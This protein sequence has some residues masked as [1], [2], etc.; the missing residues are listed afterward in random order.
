MAFA[1]PAVEQFAHNPV[2][3]YIAATR[4]PFLLA[5]LVPC[6]IGMASAVHDGVTF[7]WLAAILTMVGAVIAQAGVNV[8]NDYYDSI[9]GTDAQNTERL[10]PFTGGSRFIQNGILSED[11]AWKF[12]AGLLVATALIGLVLLPFGGAGLALVG[13]IGIVIGWA[14]SAPPL[15]LNG[16]GLGELSVAIGF[17]TLI[18]VGADMVQR[19]E[20]SS[21]PMIAAVPYAL[22]V[23][24]LLY[25]NQFPD[26]KAD[27]AV[28]KHHWVVRLGPARARWGY[29]V[30]I[31]IAYLTLLASVA[32]G[33]LPAWA[34]LGLVSLPLSLRAAVELLRYAEVPARLVPAIQLTIAAMVT[35]GITLSVGLALS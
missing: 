31:S 19:G 5:S 13:L 15:L 16:R 1:E 35:H 26:R 29:L 22:F 28:G 34:L 10:F 14:Y 24:C 6:F 21:L 2:G 32:S 11:Q 25:I 30:L 20:F 17:G 33:V 8:L 7:H 9:N 12:G 18:P 3:K 4:P 23:A 27:A